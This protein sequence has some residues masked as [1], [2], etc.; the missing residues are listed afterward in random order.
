MLGGAAV[1]GAKLAVPLALRKALRVDEEE[2]C[3][4]AQAGG[5]G[6]Q[7]LAFAAQLVQQVI[8]QAWR[9]ADPQVHVALFG[10]G[11][12]AQAA[13]QEHAMDW[14]RCLTLAGLVG[15]RACQPLRFG[16]QVVGRLETGHPGGRAARDIAG[17]QW[18]VDVEQ[19]RQQRQYLLLAGRQPL[20]RT[21]QA[22]LVERQ[23]ARTQGRQNFAVDAFVQV[24]ADFLGVV[25]CALVAG[26]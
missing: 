11:Q 9:M 13:H 26:Q 16:D 3:L 18:V 23:K 22:T 2:V 12:R 17:Q 10:L 8:T 6:F 21:L 7:Q 1:V 4:G 19:Q 14:A 20:H 25:H 24:W 15:E 5:P